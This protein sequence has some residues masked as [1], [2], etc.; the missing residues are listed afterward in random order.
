LTVDRRKLEEWDKA[1]VSKEIEKSLPELMEWPG[2]TLSWLWQVA[3]SQPLIAQQIFEH[4]VAA[5]R[6]VKTGTAWGRAEPVALDEVGCFGGDADIFGRGNSISFSVNSWRKGVWRH[7]M[8]TQSRIWAVP[9]AEQVCGF[10]VPDPIDAM[11]IKKVMEVS[12]F[13]SKLLRDEILEIV[14]VTGQGAAAVLRRLR[15]YVIIGLNLAESR[16]IPHLTFL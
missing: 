14:A 10:R 15:R 2:F 5:G 11:L 12:S 3:D 4:A 7:L 6:R 9:T 8:P 16:Y 13:D 1:W